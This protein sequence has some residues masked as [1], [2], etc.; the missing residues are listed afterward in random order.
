MTKPLSKTQL[1]AARLLAEGNSER[2]VARRLKLGITTPNFWKKNPKFLDLIEKFREQIQQA[3][4]EEHRIV[5]KNESELYI[6]E[7]KA[8]KERQ[9]RWSAAVTEAGIKG[10]RTVNSWLN[11]VDGA[12]AQ[13]TPLT[14]KQILILKSIPSYMRASAEMVKAGSDAEDKA[15]ALAH[16]VKKINEF[17]AKSVSTNN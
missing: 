3:I 2:E 5:V 1:K 16:L 10:I 15:F 8:V 7:L 6:E 4:E 14:N 11:T 9:K 12:V 17:S 13:S